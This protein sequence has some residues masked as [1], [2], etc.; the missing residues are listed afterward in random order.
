MKKE[1]EGWVS[2]GR[3]DRWSEE[4]GREEGNAGRQSISDSD[5]KED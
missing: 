4:G 5:N 1:G 3:R 2:E